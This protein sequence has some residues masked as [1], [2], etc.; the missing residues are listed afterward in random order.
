VARLVR[1]ALAG[2][3][4][5][6]AQATVHGQVLAVD[7]HD[8]HALLAA[9]QA[10]ASANK[11]A[12]WGY[13]LL[14]DGLQLVVC[15]A[16]GDGL[17]RMMQQLGRRYVAEFNR[18]HGRAGAL[19]AG[20]FRAAVVEPG[21]WL[22]SALCRVDELALAQPATAEGPWSSA[23]HH[24]GQARQVWLTDPPEIWALGN[25]PFERENAYRAC[26]QRGVPPAR[27]AA[28]ARAV[29]GAWVAGSDA[30][31]SEV[32]EATGRPTSPRR[33]GRPRRLRPPSE[34]QHVPE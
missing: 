6:V 13:A 16:T 25:T 12:V 4:H 26:L 19:W 28:L 17:G 21:D 7:D 34:D 9:L 23:P 3:A 30:F 33:P 24:L 27:A 5:Y 29:H 1:L 11:V 8:R 2:R 10:A 32:A 31:A 22:L 18:R 15:P 20:R 14:A